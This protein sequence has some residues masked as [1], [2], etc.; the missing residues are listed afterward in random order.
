MNI[1]ALVAIVFDWCTVA[2][3]TIN[4]CCDIFFAWQLSDVDW[5]IAFY[6]LVVNCYFTCIFV[7]FCDS[8]PTCTTWSAVRSHRFYAKYSLYIK[9]L[10]AFII[11]PLV[12]AVVWFLERRDIERNRKDSDLHRLQVPIVG[13][14]SLGD[15]ELALAGVNSAFIDKMQSVNG[16]HHFRTVLTVQNFNAVFQFCIHLSVLA[17]RTM[18]RGMLFS[19][20]MSLF[21]ML[22]K[23]YLTSPPDD[24]RVFACRLLFSAHSVLSALYFSLITRDLMWFG[25]ALAAHAFLEPFCA[26]NNLHLS[27]SLKAFVDNGEGWRERKRR[28]QHVMLSWARAEESRHRSQYG[29][30]LLV[31]RGFYPAQRIRPLCDVPEEDYNVLAVFW[32]QLDWKVNWKRCAAHVTVFIAMA[33]VNFFPYVHWAASGKEHPGLPSS[34]RVAL[35]CALMCMIPFVHTAMKSLLYTTALWMVLTC[36]STTLQSIK[37]WIT[38]YHG[39][40]SGRQIVRAVVY[41]ELLPYDLADHLGQFLCD[42]HL[43]LDKLTLSEWKKLKE[44]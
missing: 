18:S 32:L 4:F 26:T 5:Q 12:P 41:Q 35:A 20:S 6:C 29:I 25:I 24:P 42:S 19:L 16:M 40:L 39:A 38:E 43:A 34:I 9:Y 31:A 17:H 23:A 3:V 33:F 15:Q 2:A 7:D 10:G 14:T 13:D 28:I 27:R 30:G 1:W 22:S 36:E 8:R 11:G 37:K 21:V 44:V